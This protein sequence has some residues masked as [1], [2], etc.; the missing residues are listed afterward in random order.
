MKLSS[1]Q[2][3]MLRGIPTMEYQQENVTIHAF[4]VGDGKFT[5]HKRAPGKIGPIG[6][7]GLMTNYITSEPV[8]IDQ[9]LN[10][11]CPAYEEIEY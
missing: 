3:E 11:D 9:V 7:L 2:K 1:T 8:S 4:K 5:L 10:F 6:G